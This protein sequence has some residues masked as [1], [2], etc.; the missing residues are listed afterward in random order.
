MILYGATQTTRGTTAA[1]MLQESNDFFVRKIH[2]W[3]DRVQRAQRGGDATLLATLRRE[4]RGIERSCTTLDRVI[5]RFAATSAAGI[6]IRNEVADFL[7][8]NRRPSVQEPR[9]AEPRHAISEVDAF[10]RNIEDE[11]RNCRPL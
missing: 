4:Q 8:G 1:E 2:D 9:A 5:K 3:D 10:F 6:E 7:P 11:Y